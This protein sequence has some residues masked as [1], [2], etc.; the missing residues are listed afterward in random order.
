MP[1][2]TYPASSLDQPL[3]TVDPEVARILA[4]ERRR[5]QTQLQLIPSE[6]YASRAV[7]EATGSVMTDKYAEGYGDK[8]Y[9]NGCGE[10][11]AVEQLAIARAKKLFGCDHVN[12]Q[13]YSGA[14]ANT[15]A[16]MALIAPGDTIL[17]MDLNHGGHLTHGMSLNYSG[18]TY[19]AVHYGVEVDTGRLDYGKIAALARQH[20]PKMLVCGAS[21]YPRT[22]DFEAFARIAKDVGAFLLADISHIAGLVVT[23]LHPSPVA[24]ADVVMTTTHKTL[25]G[26]RSAILMC[27]QQHAKAIDRAVFPGLQSGPHMHQVA[28][29]A[30]GLLEAS[31]ADFVDYARRVVEN[32]KAL[33]GALIEKGFKLVS[34]GTDNH[35]CL[36]DLTPTGVTGRDA[37]NRLEEAGIVVNKNTVPGETRSPQVTSGIRPAAPAVTSRGMGP[38][39]MEEIAGLVSAAV[40]GGKGI[41]A[42]VHR[43]RERF[44]TVAYGF[45]PEDL[46]P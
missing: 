17:A 22:I 41:R 15:A 25:R 19:K 37:A 9:Y 5:L 18:I 11:D 8:R 3:A 36:V 4:R 31:R 44:P 32:S 46:A 24:L 38:A 35:L 30:V 23:G 42:E 33:A 10:V 7:M 2:A 28:A 40:R 39:E 21:A 13:V 26:P 16:Y 27:K 43:L 45:T 1:A 34:G 14:I 6:N 12:V 20:R 29:K